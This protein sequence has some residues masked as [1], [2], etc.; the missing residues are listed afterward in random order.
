MV[1][2]TSIINGNSLIKDSLLADVKD[3][4]AF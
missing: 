4:L 3:P 2:T 1:A